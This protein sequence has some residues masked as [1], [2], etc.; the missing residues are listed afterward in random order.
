MFSVRC[1]FSGSARELLKLVAWTI[2]GGQRFVGSRTTLFTA[3]SAI[4]P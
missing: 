1:T 4:P 3:W 2:Q